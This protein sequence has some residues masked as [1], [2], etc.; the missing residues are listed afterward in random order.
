MVNLDSLGKIPPQ[1][2]QFEEAVLGAIML[3]KDA[4]MEV[5][6]ILKK[7]SFY[8]DEH[9]KIFEAC[10]NLFSNNKAIDL[11]TVTEQLRKNGVLEEVEGQAYISELTIKISSASHIKYH[12]R[13]IQQKYIQ[14]E[15]IRI[16]HE[17]IGKSFDDSIDVD[18]VLNYAS[19]EVMNLQSG[20]Q[21][22]EPRHIADI[23]KERIN[24]LI[25]I[26]QSDVVFTGVPSGFTKLD[27]AT[28]GWQNGDLIII[29]A[30]P[31]TGK[32]YFAVKFAANAAKIIGAGAIFSLEMKDTQIFDRELSLETGLENGL[33]KSGKI[34]EHINLIETAFGEIEQLPIYIDD[35]ASLDIMEF[36]AKCKAL[37]MK[38]G[39]KWIIVDYLQLAVAKSHPSNREGEVSY[40]SRMMKGVAKELNVPVIALSQLNRQV[41]TRTKNFNRPQ[42]SDLRESGAIEQDAD[43]VIFLHRP[44]RYGFTEDEKGNSLVGVIEA[45]IAK[46]RNGALDTILFKVNKSFT[47]IGEI[48]EFE[49][50]IP[51]LHKNYR[52]ELT[53]DEIEPF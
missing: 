28:C 42:L 27:R 34:A 12:A 48:D 13:I 8:K 3:E 19:T 43:M 31:S 16:S 11:L 24:E 53:D 49:E 47:H 50:E 9:Q 45:I 30:R 17:V 15:L 38:K 37:K 51:K 14:R 26:S 52:A 33:I 29:A 22:K 44:D 40:I 18:D 32:T 23:G 1:A 36:M 41:E 35:T 20:S 10:I 25:K 46:Q 21:K 6:D 7:E 5:V 39:I 4:I 2:I